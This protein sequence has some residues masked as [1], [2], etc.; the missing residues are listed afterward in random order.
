MEG[1]RLNVFTKVG[2]QCTVHC[3]DLHAI[4]DYRHVVVTSN[5]HTTIFGHSNLFIVL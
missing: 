2:I 5:Q 3:T 1:D 4:N